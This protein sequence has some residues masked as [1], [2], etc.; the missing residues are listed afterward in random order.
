[1]YLQHTNDEKKLQR[2]HIHNIQYEY[3]NQLTGKLLSK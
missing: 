1:M 2:C 3:I